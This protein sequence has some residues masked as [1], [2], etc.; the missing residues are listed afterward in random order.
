[1]FSA[2]L[3]V[4]VVAALVD[5]L[6]TQPELLALQ[7]YLRRKQPTPRCDPEPDS[8]L[9]YLITRIAS[10]LPII[11]A[12]FTSSGRTHFWR[13]A[14][15]ERQL[16]STI[17]YLHGQKRWDEQVRWAACTVAGSDASADMFNVIGCQPAAPR[18]RHAACKL[19]LEEVPGEG[20]SLARWADRRALNRSACEE[21]VDR[22]P[23]I[24]QATL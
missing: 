23:G 3:G 21:F 12:D 8:G 20:G 2:S 24:L 16:K 6:D 4:R 5:A 13:T 10:S 15:T 14:G 11:W 22:R 19:Q 17:L 18:F 7:R 1:M 9:G